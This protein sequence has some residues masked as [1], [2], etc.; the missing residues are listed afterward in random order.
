MTRQEEAM[1]REWHLNRGVIITLIVALLS[2][3]G[4][5]AWW[6][7]TMET[8]V[9]ANERSIARNDGRISTVEVRQR[10]ADTATARLEERLIAM[11]AT[12]QRIERL[13]E[14]G[15]GNGSGA[16]P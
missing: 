10:D 13:L 11:N 3:A 5:T 15:N 12:L 9:T 16:R 2:N 14:N 7:A 6:A 4:A 1:V 8:R